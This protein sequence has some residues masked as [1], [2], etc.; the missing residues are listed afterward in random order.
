MQTLND[1]EEQMCVVGLTMFLSWIN[2]E[3]KLREKNP[4]TPYTP[5]NEKDLLAPGHSKA[6]IMTALRKLGG[7]SAYFGADLR[8]PTHTRVVCV[9]HGEQARLREGTQNEYFCNILNIACETRE[10]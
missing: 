6:H 1:K 8:T 2:S 7:G 4:I 3:L 9:C 10:I 5:A